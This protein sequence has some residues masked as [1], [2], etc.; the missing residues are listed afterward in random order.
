M[1]TSRSFWATITITGSVVLVLWVATPVAVGLLY[2]Q[3]AERAQFGDLFGAINALFS[4]LAL[5]GIAVAIFLQRQELQLQRDELTRTREILQRAYVT[6]EP[7][8]V[9]PLT[10]ETGSVAQIEIINSG[11]LPAYDVAWGVA[12]AFDTNHSRQKFAHPFPTGMVVLPPK[13]KMMQGGGLLSFPE[14]IATRGHT[15]EGASEGQTFL[16]V[17]GQVTYTDGFGGQ[18]RTEFCHRYNC[19]N[20]VGGGVGSIANYSIPRETARH[21]R[22]GNSAN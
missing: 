7:G 20:A 1:Q 22:Y 17:W 18:R 12:F 2:P 14:N 4:G 3:L 6:V 16:Y 9:D 10:R 5:A 8:G 15:P 11:N 21:H 13:G 19:R